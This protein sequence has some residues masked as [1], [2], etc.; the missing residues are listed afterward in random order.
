M[1]AAS[2]SVP[3]NPQ[4]PLPPML[5][6]DRIT[7]INDKGGEHGKGEIVAELDVNPGLWFF[8]LPLQGRSRH[9]GLSRS[10]RHVAAAGLLPRLGRRQGK[11]RALSVGEVKF[12]GMVVPSVQKLEYIVNS[13]AP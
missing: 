5:M 9:A 1:H 6:F 8:R 11:G 4:L 2:F 3:G 12:S 10:R 13:S 7:R